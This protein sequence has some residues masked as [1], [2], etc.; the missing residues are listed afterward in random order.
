[1]TTQEQAINLLFKRQGLK[2]DD[3]WDEY[4]QQEWE[5]EP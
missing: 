2:L 3:Y 1:M 4:H 5:E